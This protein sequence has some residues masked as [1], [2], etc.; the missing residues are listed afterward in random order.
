MTDIGTRR[1]RVTVGHPIDVA[2]GEL[3][4]TRVDHEVDGVVPFSVGRAFNSKFVKKPVLRTLVPKVKHL[5]FGPGWRASWQIEFHLCVGGFIYTKVDGEQFFFYDPDTKER[6]FEVTGKLVNLSDGVELQRIDAHLVRVIGFGTDRSDNSLV[7]EEWAHEK[8]RLKSIERTP[9]ARLDFYYDEQSRVISVTQ[10]REQRRYQIQYEGHQ[11][12]Q[13]SRVWLYL[14][15]GSSRLVAEYHYDPRG[16]LI[17]VIDSRGP[18]IHYQYDDENRITREES[19]DGSTY[20][21][22]YQGDACVHARGTD[23]FEE[24]NVEIDKNGRTTRVTNSHGKVTQYTW[25]KRGQVHR[26][27]SPTGNVTSQVFDEE[28]RPIQYGQEDG[29]TVDHEFDDLGRTKTIRTSRGE[30]TEFHYDDE[31]RL[32]AYEELVND[33]VATRVRFTHDEDHNV[34]SIQF[35]D[36]PAWKYDYTSYGEVARITAPSGATTSSFYDERGGILAAT[37]WD[38]QSWEYTRDA[39]GR[40]LTETDPLGQTL[41]ITYLDEDGRS[42]RV[43]DRDGRIYE[44]RVS[45]DGRNIQ[46]V[47]PGGAQRTLELSSCGMPV[48]LT[49]EMGAVTR[50]EWGTEPG[51]LTK[52]IHAN[53]AAYTFEYDADLQVVSRKT[54]DDRVLKTEYKRGRVIATVDGAGQKTKYDYDARGF[55]SKQTDP[56]GETKFGYNLQGLLTNLETPT[57]KL[58]LHRDGLGRI[59]AEEVDGV[60]VE[61]KLDVMGRPLAHT[62]PY[63]PGASFAWTPGGDCQSIKYG[64]VSVDFTRDAL[65]RE[66]GRQLGQAG[67]FQQGY[68]PVGRLLTQSFHRTPDTRPGAKPFAPEVMRHFGFDERGFL[69]SI[70]DAQR[71]STRLLHNARGDLTGV[72]RS[73]GVSDFYMYDAC[74]NRYFHAA[75][76]HGSALAAALDEVEHQ[77]RRVYGEPP[78]D[79]VAQV[80]QRFPH[81]RTS[82][83]YEQGGGGRNVIL[84]G[85]GRSTTELQYNANGQVI[86]KTVSHGAEKYTYQYDWNAHGELIAV[87]TPNSK[88]W[89]YRYDASGRRIEKKSPTGDV[90]RFVWMGHE[91]LH[92]LKNDKLEESYVHEPG[93]GCPILRDDGKVHFILPDQNESPAEEVSADGELEY[94]YQKGTWGEGFRHHGETGGQPFLGQWYDR[95]SGL[96]Y[97][98]F[99]YY[100]PETGRYLSPD[101]IELLG[102]LNAYAGVSDPFSEYDR[103]GLAPELKQPPTPTPAQLPDKIIYNDGG[104]RVWHNYGNV[105]GAI[106]TPKEHAPIHFHVE[107][108]GKEYRVFPS[109]APLKDSLPLPKKVLSIFR[110]NRSRFTRIGKRIGK[111]FKGCQ[112]AGMAHE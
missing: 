102:G 4:A 45:D 24:C 59:V 97:N 85:P 30:K 6:S 105:G 35:N 76:Q 10:S 70:Q 17:Q 84:A 32:V 19:R 68:D 100:D 22:R 9:K 46:I 64:D 69:S 98:H 54:F 23:G 44:R 7:F 2:T 1:G 15:D 5:P 40:V 73:N 58:L 27:I 93:G 61:R 65:G 80:A 96:H 18:A 28:A 16:R 104:V 50:L 52:I 103:F 41:H 109:G 26:A 107:V 112:A 75:T 88:K 66:I 3:S 81:T 55:V 78:F 60:K 63:G 20:D 48:K 111:W 86:S 36:E 53:G 14:P 91:L 11:G 87:T 99:R 37:N 49:D 34:T 8:Y 13:V 94:G 90:W 51:E 74:Q 43:K 71:G 31:H 57:S 106:G 25:N 29:S 33:E 101:P 12:D 108:K 83:G 82:Q 21:L 47:L 42:M 62:T 56:D 67:Y 38:G 77:D 72:V 39:M 89:E 79:A 95:E 92:T 110:E